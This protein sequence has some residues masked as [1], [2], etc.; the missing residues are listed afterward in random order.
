[1][2]QSGEPPV[3][4]LAPA[5]GPL[6][7]SAADH[8]PP[9]RGL[10]EYLK[11]AYVEYYRQYE[12]SIG[13]VLDIRYVFDTEIA[14]S[15][16]PRLTVDPEAIDLR[17]D[18]PLG[19]EAIEVVFDGE[20]LEQ[21]LLAYLVWGWPA[22]AAIERRVQHA[23]K[24][25]AA[26]AE[27]G[28]YD[29][30]WEKVAALVAFCRTVIGLMIRDTLI[31]LEAK[32]TARVR[33]RARD[34][35]T[36]LAEQSETLVFMKRSDKAPGYD[37]ASKQRPSESTPMALVNRKL[38]AAVTGA[39]SDAVALQ[40]TLAH[41]LELLPGVLDHAQSA[42]EGYDES[43]TR[44]RID[45]TLETM[46]ASGSA[47]ETVHINCPL[48]LL[49]LPSLEPGFDA[50]AMEDLLAHAVAGLKTSLSALQVTMRTDRSLVAERI[51]GLA[52]ADVSWRTVHDIWAGNPVSAGVEEAVLT[53][54]QSGV[55]REQR[56]YAL[57][58][59]ESLGELVDAGDIQQDSFDY[60]VLWHYTEAL[61]R[62]QDADADSERAGAKLS[63]AVKQL[64][65]LVSVSHLVVFAFAPQLV[66]LG[67]A[68]SLLGKAMGYALFA[69][70]LISA[71]GDLSR[72]QEFETL[73]LMRSGSAVEI[74]AGVGTILAERRR[75]VTEM[76]TD[77]FMLLIGEVLSRRA[78]LGPAFVA[79]TAPF[80][81]AMAGLGYYADLALLLETTNGRVDDQASR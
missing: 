80:M 75:T 66:V 40:A 64:D 52:P 60:V 10:E 74:V 70:R 24:L 35:Q 77:V 65:A 67:G 7:S 46:V 45:S 51:P 17:P 21:M 39:L 49:V 18:Q 37:G 11:S 69:H 16:F 47:T 8:D 28:P 15:C 57:L 53:L 30:T 4:R 13:P 27:S 62:R 34:A 14:S 31:R 44:E 76:K 58:N 5:S 9:V 68:L 20:L 1:M 61:R 50:D 38:A 19:P 12:R 6:A 48:A 59:R 79:R 2:R 81:Y 42:T 29:Q 63:V 23:G 55:E 72:L 32:C 36:W 33:A 56:W 22:I 41:K 3:V 78:A 26:K 73:T 25:A 54:A 43:E 71:V